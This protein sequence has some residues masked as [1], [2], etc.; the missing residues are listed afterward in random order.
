M[1]NEG[2]PEEGM[3][4]VCPEAAGGV[5]GPCAIVRG[6]RKPLSESKIAPSSVAADRGTSRFR[7][8]AR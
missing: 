3:Q 1:W 2:G 7:G 4:R 5:R 8:L 6:L